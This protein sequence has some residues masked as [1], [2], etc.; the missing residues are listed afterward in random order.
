MLWVRFFPVPTFYSFHR[1][2]CN[3]VNIGEVALQ[4]T[5]C[6]SVLHKKCL[7]G[8]SQKYKKIKNFVFTKF[9]GTQSARTTRTNI[10]LSLT[11]KRRLFVN[12]PCVRSH[13]RT[14]KRR[15]NWN[16]KRRKNRRRKKNKINLT[17]NQKVDHFRKVARKR[18]PVRN[19]KRYFF[20]QHV[21]FGRVLLFKKTTN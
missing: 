18:D 6:T 17:K 9:L 1:R 13:L 12:Q 4:C 15:K 14:K 16:T 5:Q 19:K 8:Y 20:S 21:F 2:C 10:S 7:G 3:T 11:I